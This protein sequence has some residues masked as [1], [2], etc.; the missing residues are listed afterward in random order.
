MGATSFE[1]VTWRD[2]RL[3]D[4]SKRQKGADQKTSPHA[5]TP[6]ALSRPTAIWNQYTPR[7]EGFKRPGRSGCR[8]RLNSYLRNDADAGDPRLSGTQHRFQ[9]RLNMWN[10]GRNHT[11]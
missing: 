5:V 6:R 3:D 11:K 4:E 2:E 10:G 9:K 1:N 8:Q 7:A